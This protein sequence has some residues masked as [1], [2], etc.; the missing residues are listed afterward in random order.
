MDE[1]DER[2]T[3]RWTRILKYQ[4][5]NIFSKFVVYLLDL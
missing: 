2:E 4:T 3:S 5:I 1:V